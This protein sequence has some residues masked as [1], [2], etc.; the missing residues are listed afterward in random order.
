MEGFEMEG[1]DWSIVATLCALILTGI[2][3]A[4]FTAIRGGPLSEVLDLWNT[5][6]LTIIIA[7]L[8]RRELKR[9]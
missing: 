5:S 7:I 8:L 2:L 3:T 4:A 9:G 1:W 6:L